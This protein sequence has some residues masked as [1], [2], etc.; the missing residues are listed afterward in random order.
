MLLIA[1]TPWT[2][3]PSTRCLYSE[4]SSFHGTSDFRLVNSS[5]FPFHIQPQHLDIFAD[6]VTEL[7]EVRCAVFWRPFCDI[8]AL[9]STTPT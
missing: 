5:R 2:S 7:V 3:L 8:D 4:I 1:H 9:S 6:V